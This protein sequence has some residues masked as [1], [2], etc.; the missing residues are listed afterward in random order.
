MEHLP[1]LNDIFKV[2]V[3]LGIKEIMIHRNMYHNLF[4]LL[5]FIVSAWTQKYHY[6]TA[7]LKA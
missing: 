5:L 1:E 6:C 3:Q 7:T 4:T 2:T